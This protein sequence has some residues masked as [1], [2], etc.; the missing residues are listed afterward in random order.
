MVIKKSKSNSIS[1]HEINILMDEFD[2]LEK[3]FSKSW[4]KVAAKGVLPEQTRE[5][6]WD[7]ESILD[8]EDFHEKML[9][10]LVKAIEDTPEFTGYL[11]KAPK[12]FQGWF[13]ALKKEE[14][15][16]DASIAAERKKETLIKS[17][18]SKLSDEEKAA[19]GLK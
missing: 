19:L 7:G 3:K 17:G 13:G 2:D 9:L 11:L 18:L 12:N 10:D 5:I 6:D 14:K 8:T 4:K 16:R 15:E 1:Q